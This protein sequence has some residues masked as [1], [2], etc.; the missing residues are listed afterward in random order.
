[1]VS[2]EEHRLA[3]RAI[4]IAGVVMFAIGI[5]HIVQSGEF[6]WYMALWLAAIILI[7][8]MRVLQL[9]AHRRT[10]VYRKRWGR[11]F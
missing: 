8:V 5:V 11:L 6:P 9:R 4:V 3:T 10:G 2:Y 7:V 1:V